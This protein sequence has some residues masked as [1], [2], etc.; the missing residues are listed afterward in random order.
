MKRVVAVLIV[1]AFFGVSAE[2][3]ELKSRG[4]TKLEAP[5]IAANQLRTGTVIAMSDCYPLYDSEGNP[6]L[7]ENGDQVYYCPDHSGLGSACTFYYECKDGFNCEAV[8]DPYQ[9]CYVND[10]GCEN[11]W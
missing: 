9:G 11:C 6:V 1:I 4:E 8:A 5:K 3:W 10:F 7:D 2:A